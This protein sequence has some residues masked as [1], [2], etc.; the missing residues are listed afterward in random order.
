MSVDEKE[1]PQTL[2]DQPDRLSGS[3][4]ITLLPNGSIANELH[5]QRNGQLT[6]T[7]PPADKDVYGQHGN[8]E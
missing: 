1:K 2:E 6:R 7:T 8:L 5:W 3:Y 4:H